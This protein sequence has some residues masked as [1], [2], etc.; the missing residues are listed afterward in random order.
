MTGKEA[1]QS[2]REGRE[3]KVKRDLRVRG[4]VFRTPVPLRRE[5]PEVGSEPQESGRSGREIIFSF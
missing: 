5:S 4:V 3:T 2:R 1:K